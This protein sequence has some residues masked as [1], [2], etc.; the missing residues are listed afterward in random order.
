MQISYNYFFKLKT[1]SKSTF[2]LLFV[3]GFNIIH[4][5]ESGKI[6]GKVSDKDTGD[7]LPGANVLLEGTSLG[8]ATSVDGG[9]VIRPVPPG[10]YNLIIKYIGYKEQEIPITV[11]SGKTLEVNAELE[12]VAVETGEV[13]I[14]AQAEGQIEAINRQL[15]SNTIKNVVSSDRIRDI[16]D[17]NAAES[18]GR[19][20]GISIIRSG[21]EGQKVTI[22][23]LS[24]KY[25]V[26]MVNGVRLESTDRDDRSVDLNMIAPN[27]LSGIEVTKALTADMDADAVGGTVNLLIGKAREGFYKSFSLQ[28]GY[29]SLA[30]TYGNY[31]FSGLLSN[32]FFDDKLGVQVSG[33]VDKYDRSADSLTATY[34]TDEEEIKVNGLIP[35]YLDQVTISDK[36]TERKRYG[37]GLVLDYRFSNGSLIMNN[38]ISSLNQN[39]I[40]QQNYFTTGYDWRGYAEDAEF[41]RTVF[42]SAFQGEFEF[43]N[44]GTDFSLSYSGSKQHNPG[45]LRQDIRTASG[46]A[47]G[48]SSPASDL[49]TLSVTNF[50][51]VVTVIPSGKIATGTTTL[52][53]DVNESALSAVLNF[54]MPFTFSD[55]LS[56]NLKVGGKYVRNKRDNDETQLGIDTD[57]G[58]LAGS[59]NNLLQSVWP[60]LG[61]A[62]SDVGL[63]AGLFADPNYDVGDFLSGNEGISS[64]IFFNLVSIEKMHRMEEI[65]KQYGYYK[66]SPLESSQYD[67]NYTRNFGAFYASAEVKLGK[68]VSFFPGIRYEK[69]GYDYTADST[70]V[71]NRNTTSDPNEYYYDSKTVHWDSTKSENWF[72]QIQL[73]V[74]P[75]D[76]LDVRLASTKSIIYP[77]YRAVS[78]YLFVD[79][80]PSVP[81]LRLGNPYLKPALTQNYDIYVSVYE[82]SIGLF[83]A[84]FF[85]KEIDNLIVPIEYFTKDASKINYRYKLPQAGSATEIHTWTNLDATSYVRGIELDWQT[86][87]WYL[88]SFLSG[89]V[90]N[91]NY[92]H[93]KSETHYPYYT[94]VRSGNPPFFT[95]RYVDTTRSGR[96]ID[97]PNDILNVTLGYDIGGFSARLSFLYQDNV[98]RQAHTTYEELDSYTAAYY[99]WDFTAYQKLPWLEGLQIYLNL[100]NITN[101]PD[102]RFTSVLKKL[103][104]VEYYGATVDLGVRYSY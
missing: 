50:L 57:R 89:F 102:R 27:I 22:R 11:S 68:Y 79:T 101:R 80:Y 94:T 104:L 43:F 53:R 34:V 82:N 30:N 17:V 103:S 13:T 28:G 40:I 85:Y 77:D 5:Q 26:M 3:L 47:I 36:V 71:F 16:P 69:Y 95:F 38:F 44:I 90:F 2:L 10:S 23:G 31:K 45:N 88:P 62:P 86:H 76:W 49:K 18:V 55:F 92:T 81:V 73:R 9:Y 33:F 46:G 25:N 20:P 42:S 4:A 14:T 19:L 93:I 70:Y 87:F 21:G 39:K 99:R 78:P 37:G 65:A 15:S 24:P 75:T 67:Y 97:Q 32:R 52:M 6:I 64:D 83:T 72:P 8:T 59:F 96:L 35:V 66:P 74:K 91:I 7:P 60:E 1:I 56:G 29:G 98:F 54:N 48:L 51:N 41:T 61:I 12:Y 63:R 58:G 84:G 100:N